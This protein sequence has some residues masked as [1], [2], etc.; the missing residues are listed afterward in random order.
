M[1]RPELPAGR[2]GLLLSIQGAQ[3]RIEHAQQRGVTA[4]AQVDALVQG[5]ELLASLVQRYTTTGRTRY[6]DLYDEILGTWLGE[7]PAPVATG[8]VDHWR[9]RIGSGSDVHVAATGTPRSMLA[10]LR[11][12]DFTTAE[13]HAAQALLD[14]TNALQVE[15]KIAF[16]AP[17]ACMTGAAACWLTKASPARPMR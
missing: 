17:R 6:L 9:Q 5:T 13:Q 2:L 12:L 11:A 14:A 15:E 16:A 8:M 3:A 10:R 7:L 1:Q 4:H